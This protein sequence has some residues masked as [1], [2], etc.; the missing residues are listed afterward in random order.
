[1]AQQA[2]ELTLELTMDVSRERI[3]GVK[4]EELRKARDL[5]DEYNRITEVELP[6]LNRELLELRIHSI[7]SH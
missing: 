4:L 7:Q 2:R 1:M 5:L 6:A 3:L